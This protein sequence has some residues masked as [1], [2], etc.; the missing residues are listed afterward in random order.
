MFCTSLVAFLNGNASISATIPSFNPSIGNHMPERT[1][2]PAITIEEMPPIDFSL[3]IVPSKIPNPIKNSEGTMLI[4]IA[5]IIPMPKIEES[6][7]PPTKKNNS[8]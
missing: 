4:S 8:D 1:D 6:M 5:R 2:W 3:H 7:I